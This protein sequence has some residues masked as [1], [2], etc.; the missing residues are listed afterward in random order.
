MAFEG[1]RNPRKWGKD[2][3]SKPK[4]EFK[5]ELLAIDRVTR[6]TSGG[7]QLRFRAVMVIWDG[8]GRVWL[9]TGKSWE[10]VDAIAKAISNAKK[11]LITVKMENGTVPYEIT[12]KFKAAK[13]MVHPASKGTGIIAGGS[14]RKVLAVAGYSDILAKRYG[15][16]NLLNNAKATIKALSSFK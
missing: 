6:V 11:H 1:K 13:I 7:R 2:G 8:K 16:S 12:A 3:F 5:E 15:S 9:G 14:A 10:V 4:K